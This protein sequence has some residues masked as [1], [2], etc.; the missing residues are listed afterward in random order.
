ME[1]TVIII[2]ES[3]VSSIAKEIVA[4]TAAAAAVLVLPGYMFGSA[5]LELSGFFLFVL[6]MFRFAYKMMASY[7]Y[8]VSE[9]RSIL[10]KMEE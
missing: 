8:T 4:A 3:A 2:N 10:D 1:K 7:S 5:A 6:L 9:A